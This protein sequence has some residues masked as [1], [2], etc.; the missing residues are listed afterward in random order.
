MTG[1]LLGVRHSLALRKIFFFEE[2]QVVIKYFEME[3]GIP[4]AVKIFAFIQILTGQY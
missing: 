4:V 2:K 3:L 1:Q